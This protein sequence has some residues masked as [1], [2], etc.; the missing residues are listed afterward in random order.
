MPKWTEEEF[1][2]LREFYGKP[3]GLD[4]LEEKLGR[5]KKAIMK[6]ASRF[7]IHGTIRNGLSKDL[8]FFS[9]PNL[10]S[11]Y[12]AG[13]IAADGYIDYS[14][15]THTYKVS[16]ALAIK[17]AHHLEQLKIHAK[18]ESCVKYRDTFAKLQVQ[19]VKQWIG[20][21]HDNFNLPKGAKSLI[22]KPPTNLS[23][24]NSLA[25][26]KGLIDGDGTICKT[27]R[28]KIGIVGTYEMMVWV[29]K[30]FDKLFPYYNRISNVVKHKSIYEYTVG[31]RR[32]VEIV[33]FLKTIDTPELERKWSKIN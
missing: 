2:I 16:I 24:D 23:L 12:W 28:W 33:R 29:K 6:V 5:N 30:I 14:P 13:F 7:S 22:L 27:D 25:F 18:I 9:T 17:D 26:I 11:S 19:G 3:N 31:G 32:C 10:L 15:E 21:L 20:D 8:S 4:I 1:R